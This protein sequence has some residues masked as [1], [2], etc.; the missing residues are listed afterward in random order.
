MGK[1][2]FL[3]SQNIDNLHIKSGIRPE[4]LAELHGNVSRL[5]CQRCE[6]QV[7]KSS[8]LTRC[9]CGGKLVS[10]VVDFGQALPVKDLDDSFNHAE[11]CDLMV[12]VGSSLVVTPAADVPWLPSK[13]EPDWS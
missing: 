9:T 1:L 5:R 11:K 4:L 2:A 12:V 3:V 6:S 13:R 10:S 7:D 8:G